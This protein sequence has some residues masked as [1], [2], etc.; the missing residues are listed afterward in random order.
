MLTVTVKGRLLFALALPTVIGVCLLLYVFAGAEKS[1]AAGM[2][3][4]ASTTLSA[5]T[6]KQRRA[7]LTHC[8]VQAAEE[9]SEIREIM[10]PEDL[11]GIYYAYEALQKKQGLSLEK[12]RGRTVRRYTY[13]LTS[14][15]G[16]VELLV[17][18][19]RVV[20]CGR[21]SPG[22]TNFQPILC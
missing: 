7:F 17:A 15:T 5:G 9:P 14:G 21:Y 19:G 13:P 18:D 2:D 11:G 10:I 22:Q 8:G 16:T 4:A 3:A 6:E 20:A 1:A 12:Y